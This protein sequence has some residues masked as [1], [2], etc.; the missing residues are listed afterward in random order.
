MTVFYTTHMFPTMQL[1]LPL[2]FHILSFKTFAISLQLS[3]VS[4][5]D[6]MCAE[7]KK[8]AIETT[9]VYIYKH[10]GYIYTYVCSCYTKVFIH[11]LST[12]QTHFHFKTQNVT[13]NTHM[14]CNDH[15]SYANTSANIQHTNSKH[16][17]HVCTYLYIEIYT[18]W[19]GT[20]LAWPL[21]M[22][23]TQ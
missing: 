13:F 22:R 14:S 9:Y 2:V 17:K 11:V 7:F 12:F 1:F 23:R 5:T 10:Y 4:Y 6:L 19:L 15:I 3:T 18:F 8:C 20:H 21:A 16:R